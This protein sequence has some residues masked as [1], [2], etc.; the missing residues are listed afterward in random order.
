MKY[1]FEFNSLFCCK[2]QVNIERKE[3]DITQN[4]LQEYKRNDHENISD[5]Y[6]VSQLQVRIFTF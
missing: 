3:E 6:E 1:C 2:M 4:E 5:S